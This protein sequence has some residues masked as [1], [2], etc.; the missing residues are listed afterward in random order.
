MPNG[1]GTMTNGA[2]KMI[3]VAT[4][5]EKWRLLQDNNVSGNAPGV[6]A[7]ILVLGLDYDGKE[8]KKTTRKQGL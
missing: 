6:L 5:I 1:G 3:E 2:N 4:P 7:G 8:N